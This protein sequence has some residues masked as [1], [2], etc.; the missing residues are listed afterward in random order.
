MDV[1]HEEAVRR[2]I[3]LRRLVSA[4]CFIAYACTVMDQ[5]GKVAN[6]ARVQLNRENE[7]FPVPVCA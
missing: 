4:D 2:K 1:Q 6:P 7:F 3:L 5:Q